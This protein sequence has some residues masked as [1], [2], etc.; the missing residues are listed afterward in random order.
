M[1]DMGYPGGGGETVVNNYYDSPN[2]GTDSVDYGDS[3][4]D[5]GGDSADPGGYGGGGYSSDV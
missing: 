5:F 4:G 3:P 2:Q 1:G